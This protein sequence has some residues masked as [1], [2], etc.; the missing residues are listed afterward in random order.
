MFSHLKLIVPILFAIAIASTSSRSLA[1]DQDHDKSCY[2]PILLDSSNQ[3]IAPTFLHIEGSLAYIIDD[4]QNDLVIIDLSTPGFP[5]LSRTPGFNSLNDITINDNTA[6]LTSGEPYR[7]SSGGLSIWDIQ[8]PTDPWFIRGYTTFGNKTI[9]LIHNDIMYKSDVLI[10]NVARQRAPRYEI[11]FG[12]PNELP[13]IIMHIDGNTAYTHNLAILDITDPT[14]PIT[15]ADPITDFSTDADQLIFD[16]PKIYARSGPIITTYQLT[17]PTTIQET[18]SFETSGSTDFV[19]RA[20]IIFATTPIGIEV[21][22]NSNPADPLQIATYTDQPGLN[23][24]TQIELIDN[25]FI[26]TDAQG[27]IAKFEFNTNPV[28]SHT[29][30]GAA[31][32]IKLVDNLAFIADDSGLTIFNITNPQAPIHI[33]TFPTA[34]I[35][36]GIDVADNI[37]YLATHQDKLNIIDVTDPYNPTLIL[38]YDSGRSTQDVQIVDNIAYVLD[39]IDGLHILDITDP[40]NPILLSI[41]NTDGWAG[42][43]TI[44]QDGSQRFAILPHGRFDLQIIDVTEPTLPTIISSIT[45]LDT[46]ANGIDAAT[47]HNGLL[48]TAEN[49]AGYRV[50]D[51][52]NP[53][54]PIELATVNTDTPLE[55]GFGHQ[56]AIQDSLLMLANGSAG[57]SIYNN[58]DPLNPNLILNHQAG[59]NGNPFTSFR[60]VTLRDNLAYTTALNG[61]LRIYDFLGCH[62]PCIA[63]LNNDTI[64]DFFDISLFL[65]AFNTQDPIADF[66]NDGIFDFF[67][68]TAFIQAFR[69]GCP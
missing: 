9:L 4:N 68:I 54:S 19:N 38:N 60:R 24:P 3:L 47:V 11:G 35:A 22:D 28:G 58:S 69:Q 5:I 8:D 55:P 23:Q 59:N 15:L 43:I 57:F 49:A 14:H 2:D 56:I 33:S 39:R 36:V 13:G 7:L 37:A 27:Y 21:F 66:T 45:P 30:P 10:M 42:D 48:Y 53:A 64:L 25:T 18:G 61:G 20:S 62:T 65:T 51:F 46:V 32:E 29:T 1:G 26:V 52:N 44:H 17:S 16:F 40:S 50:W 34:N 63:D 41:T 6:Y 12:A 31:N 67:D